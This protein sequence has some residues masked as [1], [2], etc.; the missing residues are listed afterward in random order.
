[1]K[2]LKR[3]TVCGKR[4]M[5]HDKY[6]NLC[7]EKKIGYGSVHDGETFRINLCCDCFDAL[8]DALNVICREKVFK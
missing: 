8:G 3:C 1:M 2:K 6:A 5:L 7:F 4:F